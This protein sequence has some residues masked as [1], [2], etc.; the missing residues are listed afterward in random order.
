MKLDMTQTFELTL[1]ALKFPQDRK[2]E[3]MSEFIKLKNCVQILIILNI[4]N[5]LKDY[6]EGPFLEKLLEDCLVIELKKFKP[7]IRYKKLET[8]LEEGFVFSKK[9][10]PNIINPN[11]KKE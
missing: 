5:N 1:Y 3:L 9:M 8:F 7:S 2:E 10:F 11:I 4:V 6:P